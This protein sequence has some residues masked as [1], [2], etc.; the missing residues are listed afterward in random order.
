MEARA[1]Y[2]P[3]EQRP[4]LTVVKDGGA[5]YSALPHVIMRRADLA[6]AV[7][8]LY[9]ILQGYAWQGSECRASHET[10]AAELGCSVRMLRVYL[11]KLIEA[12]LVTEHDA[13]YRRQKVYRLVPVGTVL[14]IEA[15]NKKPASDSTEFNRKSTT[16]QSEA[17]FRL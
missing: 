10:M 11:D 15:V 13:G 14:P 12:G 5:T 17:Q 2:R 16:V 9:A 7:R 3:S 4:R 6:P 8:L 1:E